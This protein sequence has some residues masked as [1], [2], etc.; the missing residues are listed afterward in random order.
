MTEDAKQPNAVQ[1]QVN[2]SDSDSGLLHMQ[3]STHL[4]PSTH[5]SASDNDTSE[6]PVREKLKKT[7]IQSM[8]K[9]GS[10]PASS[11]PPMD[12]SSNTNPER[13]QEQGSPSN[14]TPS[15]ASESRGR[16]SRKRS[17]DDSIEPAV[18]ASHASKDN[19]DVQ[20]DVKH[21]RKRS[22]DVRAAQPQ[23]TRYT[24]APTEQ[25]LPEGESDDDVGPEKGAPDREMEDTIRSPGKKRSGDELDT[26]SHRGQKIV[27]TDEA[28]AHRRSEDSERNQ[29]LPQSDKGAV[30]RDS[31]VQQEP[32]GSSRGEPASEQTIPSIENAKAVQLEAQATSPQK[33]NPKAQA[34][35]EDAGKAPSGFAASGFAAMS[36]SSAS[37]FG[38]LGSST[39]SVF[40]SNIAPQSTSTGATSSPMNGFNFT[41]TS[42][43]AADINSPSPFL[44]STVAMSTSPF[45]ANGVISKQTSFGASTF[46]S[47]FANPAAG[48]PRLTSFAAPTGDLAPPKPA[49][50][51]KT[52][53]APGDPS[54][55]EEEDGSENDPNHEEVGIGSDEVDSRFQQQEVETGE[56]GENSVFIAPRAQLY[57]YDRS[58]WHE[59]GKGTFKLNVADDAKE[60]KKARFIMRAHQTFR[61][62]LNQPVFRKMQVGDSKGREPQGKNVCFAVIDEGRPTPHLLKLSD[63]SE[64]KALYHEVSRLQQDLN[65]QA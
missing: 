18:T 44:N 55:E 26:D 6:R 41:Q 42:G 9:N 30:P 14:R 7:S 32:Q 46:G 25:S 24:A 54:G 2:A 48:A 61:V 51:G 64:A 39:T 57:F 8:A 59:K 40:R 45:A 10:A 53:G 31:I 21:A 37:P 38:S 23:E 27:A 22:R 62:L 63:E 36:G 4:H 17:Y 19:R 58:G 12:H 20:D 60:Q 5:D 13:P 65:M 11:G 29:E 52:F 49:E 3:D 35:Q 47:G 43:S 34:Q 15:P 33:D 50:S 16:L 1:A 28:K 56:S